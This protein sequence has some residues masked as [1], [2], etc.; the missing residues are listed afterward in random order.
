MEYCFPVGCQCGIVFNPHDL[1]SCKP[2]NCQ[3]G[4]CH[5]R[6]TNLPFC[7]PCGCKY[8][9]C[10]LQPSFI[11]IVS[12]IH[13]Y[14]PLCCMNEYNCF[15]SKA[16]VSLESGNAITMDELEIGDRIQ[17]GE[18]ILYSAMKTKHC[19]SCLNLFFI[20]KEISISIWCT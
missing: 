13:S 18:H 8:G 10:W 6:A 12:P 14:G 19:N 4:V 9:I 5:H 20:K 15:P 17:A 11:I 1:F 3:C 7:C 2:C 16:K